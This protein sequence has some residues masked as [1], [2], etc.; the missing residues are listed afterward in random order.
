MTTRTIATGAITTM[1]LVS[2]VVATSAMADGWAT[3]VNQ[4]A[5]R[6]VAPANL[7]SADTEEKDYG[8]A[9]FDN[10]GDIDLVVMRKQPVTTPN[11]KRNLL[12]MNESGVLVDRT[13]EYA[14]AA[15][16]GGQGFLDVTN[17]RDVVIA[18]VNNDGWRDFI[19]CPA[20]NQSFPKT[21]S[22]PRVYMNQGL[23]G[24]GLWKGFKYE[25]S[26]IPQMPEAPN[27][28]GIA[29]GDVTGD[30]SVDIYIVNYNSGQGDRLL[31]N[32]GLGYFADLTLAR[33][34][35]QM[36]S[37]G[38]GTAGAIQDMNGDGVRDVIKSENGPFKVSYNNPAQ[39]GFFNKHET[40]SS[41]AHYNMSVGEL[42]NDGKL[43]AVLSDD[44][45]DRFLLNV[46]NG[47]DG[48]AN[49][50]SKT[51][52]FQSG[53]DDGFGGN[54]RIVDINNDGFN[55]VLICD[56]D[57]DIFGCGSR[58]HF[59]RNLGNVP[60]VTIQD[61]GTCGI[62]TS[63]LNGTFDV[64]VFDI[65]GDGWKD[66][67]I[68]RCSGTR[69]WMNVPPIGIVTSYP[70]GLPAFIT[71]NAPHIF[72]VNLTT[73]GGGTIV[74]D[75]PTLHYITK[76]GTEQVQPLI[77]IGA[78]AYE[79]TLPGVPCPENISWWITSQLLPGNGVFA[80]PPSGAAAPYSALS[81]VGT[82]IALREEFEGDTSTWIIT[83][84]ASLTGGGWGVANPNGTVVA[85]KLAS[86]EDDATNGTGTKCFVTQNGTAGGAPG[87]ADVDFGPTILTSP[88]FDLS[89]QDGL[90]S[91][92][93]WFFCDDFGVAGADKMVV[94][95]SNNGGT[96]WTS[97][98]N[99]FTTTSM[100]SSKFFRVSD[101]VEPTANI[102]VRFSV[103]D[104]PNDST[105]EAGIDNFQLDLIVCGSACPSDLNG[106]GNV[107]AGDLAVLLGAW[108]SRGVPGFPGDV[109]SD[110][111]VDATDL[112]GLLGAW[113]ACG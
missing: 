16:D 13:T 9:D 109:N 37:S 77:P 1:A 93:A 112:A 105:T 57:V 12:L 25:E 40:A 53:G 8:Y 79:A 2:G 71:P 85:G 20:L 15:T 50:E 21:I 81:A 80:D 101:Y 88:A 5:T 97:V 99:I 87:A 17:D 48:M 56:F 32:D 38:F 28:C 33:M 29:A 69:I 65:N 82:E 4:T 43:D 102:Q 46:G 90:I 3:F 110:G 76:G 47:A 49:F 86:P 24:G 10:D 41:G 34:T 63:E 70:Q 107:D 54:S 83:N 19:T 61:Q 113:G 31:I 68:G 39:I 18:D 100:W 73:F 111:L 84:H 22:H 42:N 6:L 66:L 60:S 92:A 89:G 108:G 58:L 62:P 59:Y 27:G 30:G 11:G 104:S 64:A 36:I 106:D 51:Y 23:D 14:T 52:S 94:E 67:V 45:S 55:D 95:V 7:G 72:G 98:M 103:S 74:P 35:P 44:G 78:G 75:S 26:R 91:F 96:T